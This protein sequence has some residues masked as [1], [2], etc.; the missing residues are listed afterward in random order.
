MGIASLVLGIISL[1]IGFIPLCG[2]IALIPAIVALV[3][4]IVSI[5]KNK[6]KGEKIGVSVAGTVLSAIA[7]VVIIFWVFVFGVAISSELDS[8]DDY[9]YD[10]YY[11]NY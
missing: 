5:V 3:L 7:T 1:I 8:I 6:K 10:D 2:A 11:Y 9:Y 4:G